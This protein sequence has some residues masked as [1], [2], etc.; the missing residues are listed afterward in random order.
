[1]IKGF[2]FGHHEPFNDCV[3]FIAIRDVPRNWEIGWGPGDPFC[4]VYGSPI[5]VKSWSDGEIVIGGFPNYGGDRIFQA[6][7]IIV[8]KVANAQGGGLTEKAPAAAFSMTVTNA[9]AQQGTAADTGNYSGSA[10]GGP[11][12]TSVSPIAPIKT[13]TVVIKGLHFGHHEP[14]NDCMKFIE[15]RDVPRRW[16]I[17][18]GPGDPFCSVYGSPVYVKTWS[19]NE[20]V[21]GGFPN[22]GGDRIF[23][24]GDVVVIKVANAQGE[25]ISAGTATAAF[26]VTVTE[27][28]E[29][30]A[31][32]TDTAPPREAKRNPQQ[33]TTEQRNIGQ[34]DSGGKR[35]KENQRDPSAANQPDRWSFDRTVGFASLIVGVLG[36][37]IPAFRRQRAAAVVLSI[38]GLAIVL[39]SLTRR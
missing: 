22:Y 14:F 21:V 2:H 3:K 12:I 25:G 4:S 9:V 37:L 30:P 27:A 33:P 7:D 20:I 1:V 34:K 28:S 11:I 35:L 19:D 26:S 23:E 36:L 31:V 10:P 29:V 5:Y 16:D 13:Q 18:W 8:V 15:I 38:V 6:G 17:G 39:F 24:V 32:H